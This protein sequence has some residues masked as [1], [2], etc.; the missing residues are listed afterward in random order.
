MLRPRIRHKKVWWS[1]LDQILVADSSPF[2]GVQ[3]PD[4]QCKK[5]IWQLKCI[6]MSSLQVKP[7]GFNQYAA[8][9]LSL[10][11]FANLFCKLSPG[12]RC[13]GSPFCHTL[14]TSRGLA[15]EMD[16]RRMTNANRKIWRLGLKHS[17]HRNPRIEE[18]LHP[19]VVS[20]VLTK[21]GS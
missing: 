6:E 18:I 19:C 21:F 7:S 10:A 5:Q 12:G 9:C 15:V 1:R 2:Q 20:P 16:M 3:D 11:L 8:V 4:I 13:A 17:L 14:L